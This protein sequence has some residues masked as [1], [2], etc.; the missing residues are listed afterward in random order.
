M[1]RRR[2]AQVEK[3][4]PQVEI[5]LIGEA[6]NRTSAGR[7]GCASL[8]SRLLGGAVLLMLHSPGLS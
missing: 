6:K 4:R 5:N 2:A 8:I 3:R 1:R 7:K